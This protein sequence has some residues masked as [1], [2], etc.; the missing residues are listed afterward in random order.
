MI[1]VK[2]ESDLRY[3]RFK[4]VPTYSCYLCGW[5]GGDKEIVKEAKADDK[6]RDYDSLYCPKCLNNMLSTEYQKVYYG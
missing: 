3:V 6:G 2:D 4:L 1:K 5:E